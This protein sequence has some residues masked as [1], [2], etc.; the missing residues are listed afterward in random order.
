MF[1]INKL[2]NIKRLAASSLFALIMFENIAI[3]PA[4]SGSKKKVSVELV[5]SV[6]VS[7]SIDNN[8]F[9]LQHQGYIDAFKDPEVIDTIKKLPNGMAVTLQYWGSKTYKDIGWKYVNDKNSAESFSDKIKNSPRPARGGTNITAAIKSATKLIKNNNYSG[10][11]LVIDISGDGT[12]NQAKVGG[13]DRKFIDNYIKNNNLTIGNYLKGTNKCSYEGQYESSRKKIRYWSRKTSR[14]V[15][16]WLVNY[17]LAPAEH[18]YCPPLLE[19]RDAAVAEGITINGLP[20]NPS[21][22]SANTN[23]DEIDVFYKNN[24]ISSDGFIEVAQ[25]FDDFARAVKE[26]I[27]KEVQEAVEEELGDKDSDGDGIWDAVESRNDSDNDGT[28]DYLDDDSDGDGIK[29][30]VEGAADNDND[31]IPNYLDDDSDGDGIK[32]EVEY[33][34]DPDKNDD[35]EPNYLDDDSDGDGIKDAVEGDKDSDGD[36]IED[37]LDDDSDNDGIKDAVEGDKDSDRDG[38]PD[39]LDDDSDNDGVTDQESVA[40]GSSQEDTDGDGIKDNLDDDIDGDGKPNYLDDDIDGDGIKNKTEKDDIGDEDDDNIPSYLDTDSDGDGKKDKNEGETDEDN[41]QKKDYKDSKKNNPPEINNDTAT[42][43]E[44]QAV[45]IPVLDNDTDLDVDDTLTIKEVKDV[46]NG[47]AEITSDGKVKFTP[48]ENFVGRAS[49]K[50]V[51][52]DGTSN[53]EASVTVTVNDSTSNNE[54]KFWAD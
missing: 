5:L 28:P 39:Y 35:G 37:Y 17:S 36:G 12:D 34:T 20:I 14:M 10:S 19:A 47:I 51:A 13:N 24:V 6:D 11:S 40:G 22:T 3:R 45:L 43:D 31:G 41:D 49:F 33:S 25:D 16:K 42:T 54:P 26:K 23:Q 44:N 15:T 8:E 52:T 53:G 18:L 1:Q 7:G 30:S 29:D 9:N 50:Y 4:S 46:S 38:T 27:Q 32:D 48:D 2:V 21:Y